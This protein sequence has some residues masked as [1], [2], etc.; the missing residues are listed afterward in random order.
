MAT[1]SIVLGTFVAVLGSTILN[2]PLRDIARDLH[3]S[4]ANASLLITSTAIAFA[5]LLPIG[6]WLGN[7]YGRKKVYCIAVAAI[8]AAGF[9][10]LFEQNLGTLVAMRVVQGAA[11]AAI[12][13]LVMTLLSDMYESERRA[14]ALSAWATAN[15]L[16]QALGPPLGGVLTDTLGWRS[17]FAPV[18]IISA[19]TLVAALRYVPSD[20]GRVVSLQ[21]RAAAGLTFGVLLLQVAFTTIAQLG[22]HS[23]L[24]WI[25]A[26]AGVA[27]LFDFSH[28]I[29]SAKDP[30]VAPQAFSEPSYMTSCIAV[31]GATVCF[32]AALL[33]TP[34]Y[35]IQARHFPASSAGFVA[36]ALP[37]AMAIFAPLTSRLVKRF[38]SM[39]TLRG[40]LAALACAS[41][42]TALVMSGSGNIYALGISLLVIGSGVA[43]AYTAAAV[44]TTQSEAGRYG[45]GV[46]LFNSLR[47]AGSGVGAATVAIVLNANP[48]AFATIF[49]IGCGV[50][51]CSLAATSAYRSLPQ[52]IDPQV[53]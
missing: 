13:P 41:G 26:L 38:G 33:D 53:P 43:F 28:A 19:I 27:C 45:A 31:F 46:G 52:K 48:A 25:L 16:G 3:V 8:G 30:F 6:G 51:A 1:I 47:I 24:V 50:V 9:V 34:L 18:P 17:T 32:G 37:L 12:V 2:V 39:W 35:L 40:A 7:R 44:G 5:T 20:P 10:M 14:L 36:F 49:L 11:A 21:W 42:A 22:V 4:I 29:R 15:S 23:P